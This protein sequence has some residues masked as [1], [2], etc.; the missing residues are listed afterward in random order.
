[1]LWGV[2]QYLRSLYINI[3]KTWIRI[4]FS[5]CFLSSSCRKHGTCSAWIF[6]IISNLLSI[7]PQ[8]LI[9]DQGESL[10][11]HY[12]IF[13][14][15]IYNRT[16]R[17]SCRG[18][19]RTR[20]RLGRLRVMPVWWILRMQPEFTLSLGFGRYVHI[21][22]LG[23]HSTTILHNHDA[24]IPWLWLPDTAVTRLLRKAERLGSP[25]GQRLNPSQ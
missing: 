1:M 5:F 19:C 6:Y 12:C 25:M 17:S 20:T 24:L 9:M 2:W 14:C 13:L 22:I 16:L 10:Q 18:L 4:Q 7:F 15:G 3:P 23:I 11:E 8:L 21:L